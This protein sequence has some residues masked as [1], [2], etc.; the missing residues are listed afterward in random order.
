MRNPYR[1]IL[2]ALF[3]LL[4]LTVGCQGEP[5]DTAPTFVPPPTAVPLS[6]STYTVERMTLQETVEARGRVV[7]R[8]ETPLIFP[9]AGTLKAVEVVVGDEVAAG[10]TLAALDAPELQQRVL[11][12]QFD[13]NT[14]R[15]VLSRTETESEYA[16]A[17]AQAAYN[18][19]QAQVEQTVLEGEK[20]VTAV[21]QAAE[22]G[23]CGSLCAVQLEQAQS[24]AQIAT[25]IA[26]SQAETARINLLEARADR[27]YK[28]QTAE[29]SVALARERYLM[30]SQEISKTQLTAP[31]DGVIVAFNKQVGDP[32]EAYATVGTLADPSDVR[33][34]L[35]VAAERV[36]RLSV[37][38]P[39]TLQLDAYPDQPYAG[40]VQQIGTQPIAGQDA[41]EVTV[42]F[43]EGQEVPT[44]LRM[45]VDAV[46]M[47]QTREDV[48]AVP[49]RALHTF[50]GWTYVEVV[51]DNDEVTQ[52][53][54]ETGITDGSMT[55]I[56]E[57]VEPGQVVLIP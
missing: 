40:T 17:R 43:E 39:V 38:M 15:V 32:V 28:I 13:L 26:Q 8:Q 37:G 41:Y 12:R 20:S 29:Q 46:I 5:T 49:N 42:A 52:V 31:F 24:G 22:T 48:P 2:L 36:E 30:A 4:A 55:E 16:V 10:D 9:M 27:D 6:G 56:V 25:R 3:P 33:V 53:E 51:D 57:G 14:A 21:Q 44:L 47:G 45:G 34:V 11:D 23:A 50:T 19:A 54:V 35:T 7:A 1:W 18:R